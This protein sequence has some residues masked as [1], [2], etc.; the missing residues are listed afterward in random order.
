M[1]TLLVIGSGD[2]TLV[3]S[4]VPPGYRGKTSG[5]EKENERRKGEELT[6]PNKENVP[7]NPP[8][9]GNSEISKVYLNKNDANFKRVKRGH[10]QGGKVQPSG[11]Q[12]I[13]G[14]P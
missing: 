7:P 9:S 5:G 13:V 4:I 6:L 3:W 1:Q 10:E 12:S 14:Q 2:G 8:S 11:V